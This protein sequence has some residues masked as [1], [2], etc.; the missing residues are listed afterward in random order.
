M[1]V[2]ELNNVWNYFKKNL[3]SRDSNP[4]SL[5]VR[6]VFNQPSYRTHDRAKPRNLR[7]YKK[8]QISSALLHFLLTTNLSTSVVRI[9]YSEP[10]L[11]ILLKL[12]TLSLSFPTRVL[13]PRRRLS[14]FRHCRLLLDSWHEFLRDKFHWKEPVPPS[15]AG[16][17]C[18]IRISIAGLPGDLM[19]RM[20]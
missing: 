5:F 18:R 7:C 17:A 14:P 20:V 9:L 16:S 10:V 19:E 3:S 1:Y 2:D 4:R 6:R 15:A 12:F 13:A 8:I 11:L